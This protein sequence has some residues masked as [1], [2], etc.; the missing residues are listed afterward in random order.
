MTGT[1][2]S[3][4]R[5]GRGGRHRF[6]L[7]AEGPLDAHTIK[8]ALTLFGCSAAAARPAHSGQP[9]GRSQ[10]ETAN[11]G[12]SLG[13]LVAAASRLAR[14]WSRGALELRPCGRRAVLAEVADSAAARSL[15]ACARAARVSADEVVPGAR[16]VLF[17]GVPDA[18]AL[19][20]AAGRLDA[21]GRARA[22]RAGRG[23]G[24]STTAP[25]LERRRRALG[26]RRRRRRGPA[27]RDR[28]RL[29]VLRVRARASPTWPGCRRSYAVPRL[30]TPARQGPGRLGRA[31]RAPGAASTRPRRRA[32]GGCSAAPTARCGTPP[33]SEPA[34]L[35]ARHPGEVRRRMTAR[36]L[37]LT[38]ED[39]GALTTVQDRGRVG[40][41]HLGVPARRA[42]GPAGRRAGQPAGRQRRRR[43]GARGDLGR[44]RAARRRGA[45][46]AVTGRPVPVDVDG[47]GRGRGRA[48]WVPAGG[49]L[50][51]GAPSAGVRSYVAVARR[52]RRRRRCSAR[53]P[54]TRSP[55]SGRRGWWTAP[56]CRSGRRPA[57]PAA[58]RHPATA[59]PGPAAG[60]RRD[61]APTG[62]PTTRW[63][64]CARR[65][66]SS[67]ADVEPGRAAARR[68][69]HPRGV[70]DDELPSEGMVLGAVQ[71]PPD[72]QPV[73]FL[74]DHPPT[75]GYPVLA[76]GPPGRPVAVR[77]AAAGRRGAVRQGA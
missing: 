77:A 73:V 14:H 2:G 7:K 6:R 63:T 1:A 75:G 53:G 74:A 76:R 34:L 71:V 42:A 45:W 33:A 43:R 64:G 31:G 40:L 9:G 58:A 11:C 44:A 47:A 4:S 39:A 13:E 65:R 24:Q 32:A 72:G 19:D 27:H 41:A 51:L 17:D 29:G 12:P 15:A 23:P 55:G 68:A 20:R 54:P 3:E 8:R 66:T 35:R 60:R 10:T 16:T 28:V 48:E 57:P 56:S 25:D 62:S 5:C 18:A 21:R 70:R 37:T 67:S 38:V 49:R 22:G 26:D 46:V 59:A 50:R 30:D 36:S 52:H 69:S 61:R